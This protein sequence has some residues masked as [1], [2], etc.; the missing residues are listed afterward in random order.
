M[1]VR[2]IMCVVLVIQCVTFLAS[3]FHFDKLDF[4]GISCMPVLT[5]N[6]GTAQVLVESFKGVGT[7]L[8]SMAD[9]YRSKLFNFVSIKY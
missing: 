9:S 7:D 1:I 8:F 2:F 6:L 4:N 3:A 5:V